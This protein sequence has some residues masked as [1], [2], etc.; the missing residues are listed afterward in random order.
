MS[1]TSG[2]AWHDASLALVAS[3]QGIHVRRTDMNILRGNL[4]PALC[5]TAEY[6]M[7]RS[8]T[9]LPARAL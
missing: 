3:M 4:D 2:N 9:Q 5:P 8:V 7:L 6:G 1:P